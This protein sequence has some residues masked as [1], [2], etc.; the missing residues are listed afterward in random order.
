MVKRVIAEVATG[1][2]KAYDRGYRAAVM[3]EARVYGEV[4]PIIPWAMGY[5]DATGTV[6]IDCDQ[7]AFG[8][9]DNAAEHLGTSA[10]R[11]LWYWEG[12][13]RG[14]QCPDGDYDSDAVGK[15]SLTTAKCVGERA[16]PDEFPIA[17]EP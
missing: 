6:V 16:A 11:G 2:R 15:F 14:W 17:E 12:T 4:L 7:G 9:N 5:T 13:V 10:P 8:D 3:G 1:E